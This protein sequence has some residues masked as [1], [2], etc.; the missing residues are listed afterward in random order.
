[1][2]E[3]SVE[4]RTARVVAEIAAYARGSRRGQGA[5]RWGGADGRRQNLSARRVHHVVIPQW[6]KEIGPKSV[7]KSRELRDLAPRRILKCPLVIG[8]VT[9]KAEARLY[10]ANLLQHRR[11]EHVRVQRSSVRQD[12]RAVAVHRAQ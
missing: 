2:L 4:I 11:R 9:G 10:L 3:A 7:A 5:R 6:P 1:M 8:V 12:H